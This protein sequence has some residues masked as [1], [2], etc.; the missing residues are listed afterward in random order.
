M[1]KDIGGGVKGQTGEGVGKGED[2]WK[3][4]AESKEEA[5]GWGGVREVGVLAAR[6]SSTF[7]SLVTLSTCK[8]TIKSHVS[9][10]H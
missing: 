5:K 2:G 7:P 6:P 9:S 3:G 4:E 10:A 8:H 1:G